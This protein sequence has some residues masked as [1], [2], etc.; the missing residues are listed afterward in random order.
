MQPGQAIGE[1]PPQL[2]HSGGPPQSGQAIVG[3]PPHIGQPLG[4]GASPF[5]Q[6]PG[7]VAVQ[8]MR[9]ISATAS[10]SLVSFR[11]RVMGA[12]KSNQIAAILA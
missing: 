6:P 7:G 10:M 8:R 1:D 4:G 9:D 12:R 11:S 2:A 5:G 3:G